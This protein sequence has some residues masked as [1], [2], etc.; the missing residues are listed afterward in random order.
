MHF[1]DGLQ[2]CGTEFE[3]KLQKVYFEMMSLIVDTLAKTDDWQLGIALLDAF[4]IK[5]R[6]SEFQIL[7]S[8]I[9]IFPLL[10]RGGS[11]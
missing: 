10:M 4:K 6:A 1:T 5:F 7:S 9:Q 11:S 8:K 2:G 3:D